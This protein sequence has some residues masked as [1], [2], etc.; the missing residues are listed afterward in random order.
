MSAWTST[1]WSG[2]SWWR[3]ASARRGPSLD[4]ATRQ[5]PSPEVRLYVDATWSLGTPKHDASDD[6]E[7]LAAAVELNGQTVTSASVTDDGSLHIETAQGDSL[8]VSGEAAPSTI[9]EPWWLTR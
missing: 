4:S 3:L 9:G 1:D 5:T 6:T 2:H 7:W 8:E